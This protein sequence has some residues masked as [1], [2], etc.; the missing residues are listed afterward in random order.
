[1]IKLPCGLPTVPYGQ[2]ASDNGSE[3]TYTAYCMYRVRSTVGFRLSD[4]VVVRRPGTRISGLDQMARPD[5]GGKK[6]FG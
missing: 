3:S 6:F 1:M 4:R 5:S 2:T